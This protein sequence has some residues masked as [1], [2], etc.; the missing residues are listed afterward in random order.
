MPATARLRLR[1]S[2]ALEECRFL[3]SVAKGPIKVTLM[4]PDRVAQMCDLERSK[5]HY[6]NSDDFLADVVVI[7]KQMVDRACRRRLRLRAARRAELHRL[8]G[9]R[10]RSNGSAPAARIRCAGCGA[11]SRPTTP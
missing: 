10:P 9:S 4:G 5:P 6:A 8:R 2:F 7:Q 11:R 3:R 1:K